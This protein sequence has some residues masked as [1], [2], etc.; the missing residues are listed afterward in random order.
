MGVTFLLLPAAG[1]IAGV[2]A[3]AVFLGRRRRKD[4]ALRE[5]GRAEVGPGRYVLL[6]EAGGERILVAWNGNEVSLL[7]RICDESRVIRRCQGFG[8]TSGSGDGEEEIRGSAERAA[9]PDG[10]AAP[11][12][13]PGRNEGD[14]LNRT[15]ELRRRLKAAGRMAG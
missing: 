11:V 2:L 7:G 12:R 1:A 5:L 9:A 15:A 13:E 14:L 3:S 4:R 8:E 6:L 10:A